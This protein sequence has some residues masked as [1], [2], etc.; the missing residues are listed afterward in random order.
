MA[1][2]EPDFQKI[3]EAIEAALSASERG[4][5]TLSGVLSRLGA[6]RAQA[7]RARVE[8]T[9]EGDGRFFYD[10]S[11]H[12]R[13]RSEFFD[14][15]Q[16]PVTPDSWEIANGL[17]MPGHRFAPFVSPEIFP[18]EVLLVPDD[19]EDAAVELREITAP[20]SQMFHYALLLGSE[21]VFDFF[22]AESAANRG[23]VRSHGPEE[24]VTLNAFDLSSF[25]REHDFAVGDALLCTVSDWSSGRVTFSFLPGSRRKERSLGQFTRKFE[26]AL[27]TVI[28]R[29]ENYL[30]IPEQ[31]SWAFYCGVEILPDVLEWASIDEFMARSTRIEI[32]VDGDHSVLALK[33]SGEDVESAVLPDGFTV[34][35]GETGE[36]SALLR[37]VGS[38]LTPVEVDGF[39]LDCCY[40]RELDFDAFF[41]RAFGREKLRF[42][43]E[44]QQAVFY[45][46]VEDRFEEL[47]GNY[48][49]V[50]DE[51]KAPLRSTIMELVEDRLEFFDYLDSSGGNPEELPKEPLHRLAEN[52][53]QL[54]EILRMLGSEAFTPTAEELDRLESTV[55]L[56]ADDQEALIAELSDRFAD[57]SGREEP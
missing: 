49:R 11:G 15:F 41:A 16:F 6:G 53:M 23:V 24:P 30:E 27:G 48:N 57:R 43:D 10:Q 8:R 5:I 50:D 7:L 13:L 47:T 1:A 4:R 40:M 54:D 21:Q 36:F 38:P 51:P 55:E 29:F 3:E 28:D 33:Q 52:S 31:L 46:Y 42:A 32:S 17:L 45:N 39:I 25:Y 35:K 19:G 2:S 56:R 44:G 34:S 37:E 18:S 9:L 22:V 12:Y 26:Q 20:L 14:G